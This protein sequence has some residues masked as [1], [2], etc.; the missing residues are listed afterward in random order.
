MGET[1]QGAPA[2]VEIVRQVFERWANEDL[3]GVLEL[4]DEECEL[5]PLLGQIEGEDGVYRG[6]KGVRRWFTDTYA[7]WTEFR[8][9]F[10]AFC[11]V[12]DSLLVAG[13]MRARGRLSGVELDT[14]TWWHITFRDGRILRMDVSQDPTDAHV[15]AGLA[16]SSAKRR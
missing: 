2:G 15:A 6:H 14:E 11:E 13:R 4:S 16:A 3:P 12:E 10:R 1:D 9:V 8:P 7:H 5:R